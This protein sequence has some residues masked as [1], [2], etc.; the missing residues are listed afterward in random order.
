VA[1]S[2]DGGRLASGGPEGV[3]LWAAPTGEAVPDGGRFLGRQSEIGWHAALA[4]EC[5][6][7]KSWPAAAFHL[8]RLHR[9]DPTARPRLDDALNQADDSPLTRS[10]KRDL[11]ATD[12]ARAASSLFLPLL[13]RPALMPR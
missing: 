5:D 7:A 9:S 8:E 6:K 2:P 3:K 13:A 10:I 1:F 4:A 12:A 11:A